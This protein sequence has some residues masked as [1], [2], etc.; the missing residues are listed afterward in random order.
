[1]SALPFS[2]PKLLGQKSSARKRFVKCWYCN[3]ALHIWSC[4]SILVRAQGIWWDHRPRFRC[5]SCVPSLGHMHPQPQIYR[6]LLCLSLAANRMLVMPVC[7]LCR[8]PAFKLRSCGSNS[9]RRRPP[10]VNVCW[11]AEAGTSSAKR[12]SALC[13]WPCTAAMTPC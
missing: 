5:R 11:P 13:V 4:S 9:R 10:N 1:M 2:M 3:T 8:P 6:K 12:D 7:V